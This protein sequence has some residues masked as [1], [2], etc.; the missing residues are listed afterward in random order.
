M[1]MVCICTVPY[2]TYHVKAIPMHAYIF[3]FFRARADM[4]VCMVVHHNHYYSM[5]SLG[6]GSF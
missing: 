3:S 1:S 5:H 6:S 4:V 2:R